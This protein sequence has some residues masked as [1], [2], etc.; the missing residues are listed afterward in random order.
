M[1]AFSIN[2]AKVE[3]EQ[4]NLLAAHLGRVPDGDEDVP[5]ASW[6]AAM[7]SVPEATWI[8]DELPPRLAFEIARR[9]ALRV[10][11]LTNLNMRETC[12][13]ALQLSR[14]NMLAMRYQHD[15]GKLDPYGD[16]E[17]NAV[18][19]IVC[20]IS[21]NAYAGVYSAYRALMAAVDYATCYVESHDL[22]RASF[23]AADDSAFADLLADIV[24]LCGP[25]KQLTHGMCAAYP[26]RV[27]VRLCSASDSHPARCPFLA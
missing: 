12:S 23:D 25:E 2:Y 20:A 17:A 13:H 3:S 4:I 10:L 5:I 26:A 6:V 16:D 9:A 24:E 1:K 14:N 8:L 19:S 21:S 11:H 7:R 27:I 18:H 22:R 15:L